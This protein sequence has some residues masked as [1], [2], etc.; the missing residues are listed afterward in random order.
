MTEYH[1][2]S[3]T[4]KC[5]FIRL[6]KTSIL[7]LGVLR[8]FIL[9]TTLFLFSYIL[10][11]NSRILFFSSVGNYKFPLFK[12]EPD[13][14]FKESPKYLAIY[15]AK[16]LNDFIP[17][18]HVPNKKLF[19][20]VKKLNILPARGLLAFWFML[21]A[22]YIFIDNKNS[23]NPNASFLRGRFKII[24]CWHG[25]PLKKMGEDKKRKRSW[26]SDI[27]IEYVLSAC[28]HSTNVFKKLFQTENVLEIGYPRNDILLD[29]DFFSCEKIDEKLDL[30]NFEK[31]FLYAPTHRRKN[32]ALNPFNKQFLESRDTPTGRKM[33]NAINPF[34]EEF[35]AELDNWLQQNNYTFLIKQ[36]PY[37]KN[38][39]GLEKFSNI[40][41]VSTVNQDIQEL[42]V[43]TDVLIS[44]YSS[45]IFD[46]ALTEKP[47]IFYPYDYED[48]A[49]SGRGLYY[50]YYQQMPGLF[51]KTQEELFELIRNVDTRSQDEDYLRKYDQFREKFNRYLDS[52]SC[53]RLYDFLLSQK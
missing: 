21:R 19:C 15:A 48:Y 36:H 7:L 41:D 35:L 8:T 11:K 45:I 33:S 26:L 6:F 10:P 30:K 24:Q 43:N 16:Q 52:Q 42:A 29:P 38:I 12:D 3:L 40:H 28:A 37:A 49:L 53:Q 18:F 2:K 31:V 9:K 14:Q 46:F 13:F 44:D 32:R 23:Y 34:N 1:H 17:V 4:K 39:Q 25:T 50:D 5:A 20:E 22:R 27:R 51:A 47:I